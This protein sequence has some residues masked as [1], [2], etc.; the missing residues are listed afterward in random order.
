V[1][2]DSDL[3]DWVYAETSLLA[4]LDPDLTRR[5]GQAQIARSL[6]S[7]RLIAVAGSGLS[8]AYGQPAWWDLA[9][10]T[11]NHVLETV[12]EVVSDG[13]P[14]P[15][16]SEVGKGIKE[17]FSNNSSA[18]WYAAIFA[19]WHS[20]CLMKLDGEF[21][22]IDDTKF[23]LIFEV[24][25]NLL[26]AVEVFRASQKGQ[27]FGRRELE[28]QVYAR[29]RHRLKWMLKDRRGRLAG[30]LRKLIGRLDTGNEKTNIRQIYDRVTYDPEDAS[31]QRRDFSAAL[32]WR[33]YS[34]GDSS[35]SAT[36][37]KNVRETHP[38][39]EPA[40]RYFFCAGDETDWLDKKSKDDPDP[41]LLIEAMVELVEP[42]VT[43]T[44]IK[45]AV[46]QLD[47][48]DGTKI[49]H[50][51]LDAAKR[52]RVRL[53]A[54]QDPYAILADELEIRRFLTLNYDDELDRLLEAR[55]FVEEVRDDMISAE[56]E[57]FVGHIRPPVTR[58]MYVDPIQQRAEVLDCAPGSA[59]YM[60]EYGADRQDNRL[61][62]LH[63]HGRARKQESH[64]VLS[65][66][67]YRER[68]ARDDDPAARSDDA[69]RQIFTGNPLLFIGIGMTEPDVLRPLRE[70]SGDISRLTERPA[71]ALLPNE[72]PSDRK[73]NDLQKLMAS[74]SSYGVYTLLYGNIQ[75]KNGSCPSDLNYIDLVCLIKTSIGDLFNNDHPKS[76][77]ERREALNGILSKL[78]TTFDAT[79]LF[80]PSQVYENIASVEH[81]LG[82][83]HTIAKISALVEAS[84]FAALHASSKEQK[85]AVHVLCDAMLNMARTTMLC[86]RLRQLIAD[87]Q[88]WQENWTKIPKLREP[89]GKCSMEVLES[90][91][92]TAGRRPKKTTPASH[93]RASR[94]R[95]LM[96]SLDPSSTDGPSVEWARGTDDKWEEFSPSPGPDRDRFF[97]GSP[98]PVFPLMR[99]A[100]KTMSPPDG[101]RVIFMLGARGVGR[102]QIFTAM[103]DEQRFAQLCGWLGR[104]NEPASFSNIQDCRDN[105]K[106]IN[107]AFFNLGLSHE[108]I[109]VFDRLIFMLQKAIKLK[110]DK[111]ND[112]DARKAFETTAK[113][114]KNRRVKR[115]RHALQAYAELDNMQPSVIIFDHFSVLFNRDG[116][117]KN[118]Q[119]H[120]LFEALTD[121]T[122]VNAPIDF[123]FMMNEDFMPR[124]ARLN[125]TDEPK[126]IVSTWLCPDNLPDANRDRQRT[127]LKQAGIAFVEAA[128]AASGRKG[129][130]IHLL[131]PIGPVMLGVRYFPRAAASLAALAMNSEKPIVAAFDISPDE[132]NK[133]K[134][135]VTN[136]IPLK[137]GTGSNK[138]C[139]LV[140]QQALNKNFAEWADNVPKICE[141]NLSNEQIF[142]KFATKE[143]DNLLVRAISSV[144]DKYREN[145]TWVQDAGSSLEQKITDA[146][147]QSGAMDN[148]PTKLEFDRISRICG[149]NRYA[150]TVLFAAMDDM[151]ARRLA[152]KPKNIVNLEPIRGFLHRV[153]LA[154]SGVA[155]G[156]R[157]DI[158]I[159][160]VLGLYQTDAMNSLGEP[161]AAW[162]GVF[163]WKGDA[164]KGFKIN[165]IKDLFKAHGERP[166]PDGSHE[167]Q[168]V[169]DGSELSLAK[170]QKFEDV[171]HELLYAAQEEILVALS[172]IGQP[173]DVS[174]LLG[175]ATVHT[176]LSK[177]VSEAN[178]AE[179]TGSPEQLALMRLLILR[180][181]DLLVYRCL[182]FRI[183]PKGDEGAKK[184]RQFHR[185]ATHKTV[186]RH[187]YHQF[188]APVVDFADVDQLTVSLYATQ[189]NDVPKPSAVGH[190][191]IRLMVEQLSGYERPF[192]AAPLPHPDPMDSNDTGVQ[193][194]RLRAAYG[195]LRSVYSLSVVSRFDTYEDQGMSPPEPGYFEAHR[196]RVRWLLRKAVGLFPREDS[197]TSALPPFHAEEIVWLFN[198]CGVLSLAS[199]RIDDAENLLKQARNVAKD[200][201]EGD[202][203]GPLHA[204]INLNLALAFIESG[205]TK[206]A[207]KLLEGIA[208]DSEE[209]DP[210]RWIADGYRG[211]TRALFGDSQ[212]A[213]ERFLENSGRLAK[214][215][216]Y[217]SAAIFRM[218]LA[219]S[220]SYS[221][222]KHDE[223]LREADRARELAANGGHEDIRQL[224][225][226]TLVQ[227]K[228]GTLGETIN[229]AIRRE[230]IGKLDE[231]DNY[232][233]KMGMPRLQGRAQVARA[234]LLMHSGE[235]Q[236]AAEA[237]QKALKFATRHGI[238]ILKV[239][240][241]AR[242][243]QA[244][245]YQGRPGARR[246][247]LR[248]R[249][250]AQ[251]SDYNIAVSV[252]EAM[253]SPKG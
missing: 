243:G 182:A 35:L 63:I 9:Q 129:F 21:I 139:P 118:A 179:Y 14:L 70:Y 134:F 120:Q 81:Q 217:R 177:I 169:S 122:Y 232:A 20:F 144:A 41:S 108:V 133:A 227:I 36:L 102:G 222:K 106:E 226:L 171:S 213:I 167:E 67:D 23:P 136:V 30:A 16:N 221:E 75:I 13:S 141:Q 195:I 204:R 100:L 175:I 203:H 124:A 185:F 69:M 83:S 146:Y 34:Q 151:I 193:S 43:V 51:D 166:T 209:T 27:A 162:P 66:R 71:V 159:D 93:V 47:G 252:V 225:A 39:F 135:G 188:N 241:L 28:R 121:D 200:F 110:L 49:R 57:D 231:A 79:E 153:E 246:L 32:A 109:S 211:L 101:R 4:T 53:A 59:A 219:E 114:Y 191:R 157:S 250:I 94:H 137:I 92:D 145:H 86:A 3:G 82:F 186:K 165:S 228:I 62:A 44:W 240:A 201:I 223:A 174:V 115:L 96:R 78:R 206:E 229:T 56:Q 138:F 61:Q 116:R 2:G 19:S 181:M 155:P 128:Q 150:M 147:V 248:A 163:E 194:S 11:A 123:I 46:H 168:W 26:A 45:K 24:C 60:F 87:R 208:L 130:A 7:N 197:A 234:Q 91:K 205:K 103:R 119:A 207:D 22:E 170:A 50:A 25:E 237:S 33:F 95:T 6:N 140:F 105:T 54:H 48:E 99:A 156:L 65:E 189:P 148:D 18:P 152:E 199:G 132:E 220:L 251:N 178:Q 107:S 112:E 190:R 117:P 249:D 126:P 238:E 143:F 224:A 90:Q 10:D 131:E 68:Y 172:L 210:I 253:L 164:E 218:H 233:R 154:V 85:Q 198:E 17:K 88:E 236:L 37:Y 104:C 216:R 214:I 230:L 84:A 113:T 1:R 31:Q 97:A 212:G 52:D 158:V 73:G 29:M 196:L 161:L 160:H 125:G 72:N 40:F 176:A 173:V 142:E 202:Q 245:L 215:G 15:A 98:S 38:L 187:V 64:L 247:L 192:K 12:W 8:R 180:I 74:L 77:D 55:G 42:N 239:S 235:Y 5:H 127:E 111:D 184:D 242:L 58:S 80:R 244:M 149:K 76:I 183:A 89:F